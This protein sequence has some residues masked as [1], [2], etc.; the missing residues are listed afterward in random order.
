PHLWRHLR[1]DRPD[2]LMS[3]LN[4]NNVV[5]VL[6]AATSLTG[7]PVIICQHNSLSVEARTLGWKYRVIP[8]C[9]R[10]LAPFMSAI[11]AV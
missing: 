9:Y 8:T 10:L 11:V 7:T 6:A 1:D 3:S 5:A 4:H 2:L